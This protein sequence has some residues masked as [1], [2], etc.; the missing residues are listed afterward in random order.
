ME[1]ENA[2]QAVN[3]DK[4]FEPVTLG[5]L[6]LANRIVMAPMTRCLSPGGVP[7]ADVARYY[8]RRIE[9][10]VGLIITEGTWIPHPSASNE[11]DVPRFYGADALAGWRHVVEEVH[12]AGGKI[13]PQLWHVGQ[14]AKTELEGIYS[15]TDSGTA[16]QVGPSGMVGSLGVMPELIDT[17]ATLQEI[18]EVSEAYAVAAASAFELGFDGVELHAAHGYIF[19]Q[20]FWSGTNLR[21]DSY[22]GDVAA[23][24]RFACDI[25]REIRRRTAPDFPIVLRMSQWKMHDYGACLAKDPA[26]LEAFLAPLTDA[27]VDIYHCSQRRFW[28][29]EFSTDL[30]L[31]GWVAKLSGKPTITVGSV[32]LRE[33]MLETLRGV[34]S[35]TLSNLPELMRRL[36]RGDFDLVAVGR[37][38][39]VDPDWP[40]KIRAGSDA[41]VLPYTP[42]A[43][44]ELV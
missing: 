33:D 2:R 40:Q 15:D 16:R 10:G 32:S 20:F 23:R 37:A 31:A 26:E 4:L 30:N 18:E 35:E 24:T 6:T 17:P 11:A 7:G 27:G 1:N 29:G 25:V 8:R 19:D 9:G 12:A 38:L 13:M 44:A 41:D 3:T 14:T 34:P 21:S 36:H 28:E 39:I 5:S 42:A 22:G 43:L